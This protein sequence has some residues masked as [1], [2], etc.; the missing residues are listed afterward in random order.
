MR[1]AATEKVTIHD[2]AQVAGVSPSTVS[3][4]L[5]GHAHNARISADT[6]DRVLITAA[7]LCYRPNATARSLR[8][9]QAQTIGIIASN[10]LLPFTTDL[11]QMIYATC[12]TRGYHVLVGNANQGREGWALS[13]ILSADRVDGILLIGDALQR[14]AAQADMERL[15]RTHHHVVSFGCRPSVAG[16]LSVTV[17]NAAG[18]TLALEHLMSLGHRSIAYISADHQGTSWEDEQRYAAYRRFMDA[19]HLPCGPTHEV[20]VANEIAAAQD[21]VRYLRGTRPRP[22]AAFITNDLTALV[23]LKAATLCGIRVPADLSLVGF[24]DIAFSALCTPGLT[25]VHQPLD[26]MG[27]YAALT[28][29]DK[30]DGAEV[31]PPPAHLAEQSGATIVFRPTLIHRESCASPA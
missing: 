19:H 29:L 12:H 24:D 10:L 8:T 31:S 2:V 22:T 11:L 15:V 23:I 3:R 14:T 18:V 21:A 16:E 17:D 7:R 5:N 1:G 26:V 28:L 20:A 6:S 25:T 9:T 27:R 13:D 30:I 4:V